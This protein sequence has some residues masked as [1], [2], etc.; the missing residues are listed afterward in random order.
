MAGIIQ[1]KGI[2]KSYK[3]QQ[4]LLPI[5]DID[6]WS[7]ESGDA[8]ALLGPS[9]SGKST[10]LHLLGGV[11][12][13]DQG[14]LEVAGHDVS[15]MKESERDS[16]RSSAVG[17]VFQDFYL[18]PS[19]TVKQNVEL[20]M[21][22]TMNKSERTKLMDEWFERVGLQDRMNQ[23]P[24][25]LSRGQQQRAAII[26]A[27]INKPPIVLADEPTGSLDFETGSSVMRLLLDMSRENGS[28]LITV[29]H[30]LHL[31]ELFP[32]K[33][34]FAEINSCLKGQQGRDASAALAAASP[35]KAAASGGWRS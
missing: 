22:K 15:A 5:I 8:I 25:R 12:P 32:V 14:K 17:Y 18:I 31:A 34:Q 10:F 6:N 35:L 2:R 24:S 1:A 21:P 19:L 20:V 27:M 26:R 16:Y 23:L 33:L 29:T 13:V 4:G 11:L 30:D 9:G 3:Y 7:A 28:T